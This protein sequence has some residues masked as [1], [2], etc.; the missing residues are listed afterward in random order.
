[1][2]KLLGYEEKKGSFTNKD[3]GEV[4]EY[5]NIDLH[6]VTDE[7]EGIKGYFCDCA[8]AKAADLTV[9]GAKD[10]DGALNKEV[11]LLHDL[12]AK[13]DKD[14]KTRPLIKTVVVLG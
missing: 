14:G 3:T 10:L 7:K 11:Y 2:V 9:R 6:Y 5:H 13:T 8:T 4:V 12:T 1:M